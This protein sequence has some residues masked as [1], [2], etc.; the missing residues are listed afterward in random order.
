M[1]TFTDLAGNIVGTPF[2]VFNGPLAVVVP[3]GA[4]QLQ[5]GI[6]DDVFADNSGSLLVQ[7]TGPDAVPEPTSLLLLGSAL[8][9][10]GLIRLRGR[11]SNAA[12]S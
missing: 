2:A 7:V 5:L 4:A 1:G 8:A 9:L 11:L 10:V 12:Q 6:D 3:V